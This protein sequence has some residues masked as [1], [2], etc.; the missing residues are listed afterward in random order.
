MRRRLPAW[1]AAA[2]FV[3]CTAGTAAAADPILPLDQVRPG[4]VG[5]ARTVVSGTEIV[6]FPVTVLDV[7][8]FADGPGG[9][10]IMVRASGPL[11]DQTGGVAD[12]MSG[13]P[14][15]VTGADGVPRV[16][17][18][19]AYGTGDE[20]NVVAGVTPIEQ[21]ID[22]NAGLRAN[23]RGSL[24]GPA[25][26]VRPAA[27][28][29]DRATARA[30]E[31]RRPDRIGVFPLTRWKV[32][33]VSP[34]LLGP[35][36]RRLSRVGIRLSSIPP[37]V[38]P[39]PVPLVPGASLSALL[40][41][42]DVS[43]GAIGAVTYVDGSTIVGFG[44]SLLG[45]GRSRFLMGDA[46]VYQTIP[47]PAANLSYKVADPGA[48]HGMIVG[49]RTDGITGTEG[50]VRA[51]AGVATATNAAR[52][53]ESTVRVSI[54]PDERIAT[55]MSGILQDE[56]ALRVADGAAPGTL[57]LRISIA[58]PDL[59]RPFVYRNVFA[60]REDVARAASGRL[61]ALVQYLLRNDLRPVPISSIDVSQ[62]LEPAVR[63]A[64]LVAAG[65]R[66]AT[67]PGGR[68]TLILRLRPWRS[69]TVLVRVPIRLPAGVDASSPGLRVVPKVP[70][71]FSQYGYLGDEEDEDYA[72]GPGALLR[73]PSPRGASRLRPR[74]TSVRL[75]QVMADL[76]TATD[77]RQ[78]AV[79]LLADEDDPDDRAAGVTVAVPYVIYGDGVSTRVT[80]R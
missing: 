79:R 40:M 70:D 53:A 13:S 38:T 59:A 44:H 76:A 32:A 30:L 2:A 46:R 18:A 75:Q 77:D 47:S 58:S 56:P 36:G 25:G 31:A 12:G 74:T 62:R 54:A 5:E 7:L 6:T 26:P 57:T 49:D 80:F 50:P 67:R 11:M 3:L 15:Y 71:S 4:M 69:S 17:G 41:S 42:G 14:V 27:L 51:I 65:V 1:I 37:R 16:M 19:V 45:A 64:T 63:A 61:P 24:P 33:G 55:E 78:D 23:E 10:L 34:E 29:R 21:M 39:P 43:V 20:A 66:G 35:L 28:V 9:T 48:L 72:L 8:R 22:S 52:G 60:S 73:N 68:A